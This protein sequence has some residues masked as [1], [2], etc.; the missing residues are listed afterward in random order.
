LEKLKMK[1]RLNHFTLK[2]KLY[3]NALHS[4]FAALRTLTT[5]QVPA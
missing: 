2:S 5:A 4:A 1:T 3:L